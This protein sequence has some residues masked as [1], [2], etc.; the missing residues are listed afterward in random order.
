VPEVVSLRPPPVHFL[1]TFNATKQLLFWPST[2]PA[3]SQIQSRDQIPIIAAC[4]SSSLKNVQALYG[5]VRHS[6]SLPRQMLSIAALRN[7]KDIA[8]YCLEQGARLETDDI[9]DIHSS[10]MGGKPFTTC[11]FLVAKGLDINVEVDDV[12]TGTSLAS[13]AR[14]ASVKVGSL[15]LGYDAKLV[16]S[17]ALALAAQHGKLK[18]VKFLLKEGAFVE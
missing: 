15:L 12:N 11:M 9:Y 14:H 6:E 5:Q 1:L 4:F 3:E 13:A 2:I 10:I 18:M 8:S 16:G 17:G 7:R